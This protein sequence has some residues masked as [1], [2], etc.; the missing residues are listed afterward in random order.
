M[1]PK[2]ADNKQKHSDDKESEDLVEEVITKRVKPKLNVQ[3]K[4]DVDLTKEA[5]GFRNNSPGEEGDKGLYNP[6]EDL[7]VQ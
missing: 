7:W 2:L 5:L 4:P 6:H 3:A 1:Y